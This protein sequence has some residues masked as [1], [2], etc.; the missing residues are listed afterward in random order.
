MCVFTQGHPVGA[1]VAEHYSRLRVT[2]KNKKVREREREREG[3]TGSA[4][5]SHHSRVN[6]PALGSAFL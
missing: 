2:W 5:V 4:P 6:M 1:V 3:V